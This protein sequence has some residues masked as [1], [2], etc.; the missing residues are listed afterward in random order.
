MRIIDLLNK[1]ANG[2]EV[3]K[4][5]KYKGVIRTYCDKD[6]DYY[7]SDINED[8]YLFYNTLKSNTGAEFQNALNDKVEIIE[9]ELTIE[10]AAKNFTKF[11]KALAEH[12]KEL[13]P[14]KIER[15]EMVENAYF[16][17]NE[18][19]TPCGLTKHSKMIAEKVNELIKIIVELGKEE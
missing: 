2:E 14:L 10:Q 15:N 18:H 11:S 4:K 8:M 7:N 13:K 12:A 9:E 6:K 1:I 5:I 19:G 16:I 3:P 17:R